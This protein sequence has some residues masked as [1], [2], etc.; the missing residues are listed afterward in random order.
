MLLALPLTNCFSIL[1]LCEDQEGLE[2]AFKMHEIR[3]LIRLIDES[4]I[5]EFEI[6]ND[7]AKVVIKKARGRTEAFV[8]Q[9]VMPEK[10]QP[11]PPAT[12]PV[13]VQVAPVSKEVPAEPKKP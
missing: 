12:Q 9:P 7:G 1:F 2:M 6:D 8:P 3:E 11:T 13:E 5:E 10:V 4:Q